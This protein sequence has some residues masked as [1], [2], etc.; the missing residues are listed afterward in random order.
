MAHFYGSLN[1][2]RG[3]ATRC[4]SKVSGIS[5]HVRGAEA[6]CRHGAQGD[7]VDIGVT[8]GSNGNGG[9]LDLGT[10]VRRGT[11]RP[12]AAYGPVSQ[13]ASAAAQLIDGEL[14]PELVAEVRRLSDYF[15]GR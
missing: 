7:Y 8:C 10:F 5:G 2:A 12:Q 14:T 3:Q 11:E 4:G 15:M 6:A 9:I 13:L 1:G